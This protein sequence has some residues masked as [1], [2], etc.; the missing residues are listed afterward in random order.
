MK[1][2]TL[3]Q[4]LV[5]RNTIIPS[6]HSLRTHIPYSGICFSKHK[7]TVIVVE[8]SFRKSREFF[9]SITTTSKII[10]PKCYITIS[11]TTSN[12]TITSKT[13]AQTND[14]VQIEINGVQEVGTNFNFKFKMYKQI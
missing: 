1:N 13:V 3:L 6:D 10:F 4:Y 9:N 11:I 14:G 8:L 12:K 2:F 5:L 7:F